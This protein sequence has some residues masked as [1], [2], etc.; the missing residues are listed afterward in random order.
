MGRRTHRP[1]DSCSGLGGQVSR[2][3]RGV[4]RRVGDT[5]AGRERSKA[6]E[7]PQ[8]GVALTVKRRPHLRHPLPRQLQA[9]VGHRAARLQEAKQRPLCTGGGYSERGTRCV[10]WQEATGPQPPLSASP[11]PCLLRPALRHPYP[12]THP[13]Q[14]SPNPS[15][16]PQ[17]LI[18]SGRQSRQVAQ[19]PARKSRSKVVV[20]LRGCR[21]W[22]SVLGYAGC[23]CTC[24]RAGPT[25]FGE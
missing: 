3:L 14:A 11:A 2:A 22:A 20:P 12:P 6:N 25:T 8:R 10:A 24:D 5:A 1:L 13:F 4:V 17:K 18:K 15:N 9:E 23:G 21:K 19:P 16:P 7:A